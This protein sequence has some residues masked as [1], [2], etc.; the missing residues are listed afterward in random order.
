MTWS[1]SSSFNCTKRLSRLM[2][3][4]ATR[5][6]SLP[7]ASSALRHQRFDLH[8]CRRDRRAAHARARRVRRRAC[9][10]PRAACRRSRRSR[11]ARAARARSPPPMAPVAPVTSAVLPVRSNIMSPARD[12]SS[13]GF[14]S[15][16][17]LGR[18][19]RGCGRAVGDALD[20]T[21]QH[22]ARADLVK[23]RHALRRHKRD[24]FAPAHGAGHLRDQRFDDL[25]GIADRAWP[26]HWRRPAR[27]AA[28]HADFRQRLGHHV[29]GRLHQ[30]AMERR[31][32]RQQHRALG[33]LRPWR[34]RRRARP[35]PC[36]R[37]RR[38]ARAPLSFA[39]WQT[40]PCAASAATATA[41]SKSSPSSAAMAPD[42]DRHGLLHGLAARAQ[43][44]RRIGDGERACRGQRR[45]FAER[46][47]GDELGIA[48]ARSRPASVCSTRMTASDTA[49]SAGCAFCGE[50]QRVLPAPRRSVLLRLVAER[51]V[52][53]L[54]HLPGGAKASASALPMPTV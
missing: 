42:A 31:G 48:L 20:Q 36:C 52:D 45:I 9:R 40:S 51:L 35:P 23:L 53:F 25:G 15:G 27:R 5:M 39:A 29:G 4:L 33:A 1:Q 28:L 43:K 54:E 12:L 22:L 37:T 2:P 17:V 47:A 8:P 46:M 34:S 18:A 21:A 13:R 16:D 11:L 30:R 6:S 24:R 44:P 26:A 19:D 38:P 10:A 3:A 7:I 49:I 41:A 32:H 50:R 14:E